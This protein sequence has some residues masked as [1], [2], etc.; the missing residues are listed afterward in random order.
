[1]DKQHIANSVVMYEVQLTQTQN[2]LS[3]S[4]NNM[5][6]LQN[7]NFFVVVEKTQNLCENILSFRFQITWI[8]NAMSKFL[9]T[10]VKKGAS[11]SGLNYC[12]NPAYKKTTYMTEMFTVQSVT[13]LEND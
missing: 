1:M 13:Y 9:Q 11:L 10:M 5:V 6:N 4:S 8:P 12:R 2:K 7:L 3:K